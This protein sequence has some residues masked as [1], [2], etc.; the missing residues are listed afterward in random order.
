MEII[1]NHIVVVFV[2]LLVKS[3]S[4]A[5][6]NFWQDISGIPLGSNLYECTNGQILVGT[7]SKGI[8]VSKDDGVTFF[9]NEPTYGYVYS[10]SGKGNFL[11]AYFF[12]ELEGTLIYSSNNGKTW[13][14]ISLTVENEVS[15]IPWNIAISDSG[16]LFGFAYSD[17]PKLFRHSSDQWAPIGTDVPFSFRF[18][19][20]FAIDHDNYFYVGLYR[21]GLFISSDYGTSWTRQLYPHSIS[22]IMITDSN[23]IVVGATSGGRDLTN[24][25]VFMSTDQ[26]GTWI[27][28]GLTDKFGIR[29]FVDSIGQILAAT[30]ELGGVG[31][32]YHFDNNEHYW[33]RY[34]LPV[35][36]FNDALVTSSGTLLA[37]GA[38]GGIYRSTDS[39][40][41]WSQNSPRNQTIFTVLTINSGCVFV[42]TLG[43]GLFNSSD[44]GVSWSHLPTSVI[45]E[46]VYS[47]ISVGNSVY[48]GT[49]RGVYS[50]TDNG[51][52]WSNISGGNISGSV[53]SVV[54]NSFGD[55]FAATNFGV[56]RS[57][58]GSTWFQSGLETS[59]VSELALNN[60]NELYAATSQNG[61]FLSTD[62]G[63]NWVS[64]GLV[65]NDIQTLAVNN[66]GHVF[67]G[68][69]G[70]IYRSTDQGT[71]WEEKTIDTSYVYALAFKG[72]QTVL[73]G[74]FNG[75]NVSHDNGDHWTLLNNSGLD[76]TFVLS[77]AV[78]PAGN[79]LAGT[80]RGGLYRTT[81]PLTSVEPVTEL[82]TRFQ[83]F[84]NYPNPFNPVTVIR[85]SLIVNSGATLKVFDVLGREV[86]TLVNE[87]KAPGVYTVS[88]DASN[89]PSGVYLYRLN[90]GKFVDVRKMILIR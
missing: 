63:F 80:Y 72:A 40:I 20:S 61:I 73:A 60:S 53:Y 83:L 36:S 5:Q 50:S 10:L 62:N 71:T 19:E 87:K 30:R 56:Y 38:Q 13:N 44:G 64:I 35:E 76:Q 58:D 14:N 25:G 57:P 75:V 15:I 17:P 7:N 78:D 51:N 26:G 39:G 3:S 67:V 43:N 45:S 28:F 18:I 81:Q 24:G 2:I 21:N 66:S 8:Y 31:G 32:V 65:R 16:F 77:L 52:E 54:V 88:W 47:L 69:Y 84:Q 4:F 85:Y 22:A 59:V 42:G 6:T 29:L 11:F 90:S 49:D 41:F 27:P 34:D 55:I 9:P 46:Y 74:T 12:T 89:Q 23:H 68:V 48:A 70:G 1:K 86:A 79:L 37:Y 33:I 82:P